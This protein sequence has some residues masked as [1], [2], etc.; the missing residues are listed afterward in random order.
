MHPIVT[1]E[2]SVGPWN[3]NLDL[4]RTYEALMSISTKLEP[5]EC[6]VVVV[7]STLYTRPW[8]HVLRI[9]NLVN[10]VSRGMDSI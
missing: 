5:R 4:Y 9:Q 1:Q 6:N 3:C 7:D 10:V 2:L 8:H